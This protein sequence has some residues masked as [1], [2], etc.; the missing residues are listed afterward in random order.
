PILNGTAEANATVQVFEGSAGCATQIATTTATGGGTWS[1]QLT[2]PQALTDGTTTKFC[3]KAADALG[4]TSVCTNRLSYV[5]E[6]PPP[7]PPAPPAPPSTG[8][9]PT[10]A[11]HPATPIGDGTAAPGAKVTVYT[12]AACGTSLGTTNANGGGAWSYQVTGGQALVDG[13]TTFWAKA[14]D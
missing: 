1:Y 13:T 6:T 3:A 4:N 11:G 10:P 7:A 5:T 14:T 9:T 8:T 2:G 12:G